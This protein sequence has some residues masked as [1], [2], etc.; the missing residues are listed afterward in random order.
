MTWWLVLAV[1]LP[2][3]NPLL[4][5][6]FTHWPC[7]QQN[8][9]L[10]PRTCKQTQIFTFKTTNLITNTAQTKANRA[11]WPLPEAWNWQTE[12]KTTVNSTW[13]KF[14]YF[15][16]VAFQMTDYAWKT[17]F[18][19]DILIDGLITIQIALLRPVRGHTEFGKMFGIDCRRFLFSPPPSP[20]LSPL[21]HFS[22][23]FFTPGVLLRSLAFR[24]PAFRSLVRSSPGKRK[25]TA[26]TQA[27]AKMNG[28]SWVI[29]AAMTVSSLRDQTK[30][31]ALS[32]LADLI[33]LIK[34]R[35][36]FLMI[37]NSNN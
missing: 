11:F 8:C 27:T 28:Q 15:D 5:L 6:I 24:S 18:C 25:K 13:A 10:T 29:Y 7:L 34:W 31:T 17:I 36:W 32:S 20:S 21:H 26:A 22:N 12:W 9:L 1:F 23:F 30:E 19:C 2:I 37:P 14:I 3:G 35:S 4:R 33:I 16:L